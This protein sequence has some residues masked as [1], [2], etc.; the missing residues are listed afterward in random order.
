MITAPRAVGGLVNAIS[1]LVYFR[2]LLLPGVLVGAYSEFFLR[3]PVTYLSHSLI[4]RPFSTY[5]YGDQSVGQVIGRFVTPTVTDTVNNYNAN[6]IAA[7]GIAGFSTWGVPPIFLM[8]A[9]W[10]WLMSKLT[11]QEN[12][13]IVCAMLIPFVVSLA[14][15]SLF[16]AILTGGGAA[17]AMLLY[18]FRSAEHTAARS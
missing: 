18:L 14:D 4:G 10:L 7:D 2:I 8:A 6:F 5:P 3:Y 17:A 1:D 9:G 11:G 12:R 16:T 15:A 13:A